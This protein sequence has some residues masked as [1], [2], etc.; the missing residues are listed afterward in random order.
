MTPGFAPRLRDSR[1]TKALPATALALLVAVLTVAL[2]ALSAPRA[3]AQGVAA[4]TGTATLTIHN[5]LCPA[6]FTGPDYF[7]TCHDTPAPAGL[8]FVAEGPEVVDAFNDASGNAVFADLTPGTYSV[9]GGVP[10]D[11][12]KLHIACTPAATPGTPYPFTPLPAGG[13]SAT[14]GAQITLAAGANIVCDFYNT[15][16]PQGPPPAGAEL[17]IRGRL[18]PTDYAG[19]NFFKDCAKPVPAGIDYSVAGPESATIAVG[20]NGNA[21]FTDLTSGTYTVRGGVPGEFARLVVAC[22]IVNPPYLSV[23]FTPLTGGV[24][25]PN[26]VTGLTI[27]LGIDADVVCSF[28]NIPE[29]LSGA[30]P[31]PSAKPSASPSAK[32]S[33]SAA[34]VT[35]LPNTGAGPRVQGADI[36]TLIL[37][38]AAVVAAAG[39]GVA[40]RRRNA[41]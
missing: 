41:S 12:A 4:A 2:T 7:G 17:T 27:A 13:A 20:A 26:D 38:A 9:R 15:P 32:P 30:S 22:T 40:V 1:P 33:A 14:T 31:S 5:R 36:S 11:F 19:S 29:D 34:P 10:L 6:G 23:P 39:L 16:V 3:G 28:Y 25:G 35:G 8:Q 21:V 37:L 24:R 18:C